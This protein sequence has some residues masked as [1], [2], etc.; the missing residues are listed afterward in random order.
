MSDLIEVEKIERLHVEPGEILAVT[1]PKGSSAEMARSVADNL[2]RHLPE[3]V[4]LLLLAGDISL[5]VVA[6]DSV[7]AT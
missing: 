3:G 7:D 5:K 4:E 1:L 6:R 2:R